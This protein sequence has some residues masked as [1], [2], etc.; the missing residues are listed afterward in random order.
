MITMQNTR[1]TRRPGPDKRAKILGVDDDPVMQIMLNDILTRAGY[2]Y[3]QACDASEA[4][5]KLAAEE[6]D[7]VL[8]DR[9]L[10][11]SDGLL[12][13][14]QIQDREACPVIVISAMNDA[15]DKQLGLGLGASDYITKPF[16]PSELCSRVDRHLV[17]LKEDRPQLMHL[18]FGRVSFVP[19]TRIMTVGGERT[20]LPPAEAK[21]FTILLESPGKAVSRDQLTYGVSGREWVH[22]DRTVDV[23]VSRLRRRLEETGLEIVTV[24]GTGYTILNQ[25]DL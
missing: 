9:Q 11:D 5:D 15:R 10:P 7:L 25:D 13:L 1:A 6:F 14:N 24:H 3:E 23:L 22:G 19:L 4:E 21:L 17:R 18:S 2:I 20:I 8:L 16:V 12:L